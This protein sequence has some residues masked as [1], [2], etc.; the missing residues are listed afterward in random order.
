MTMLSWI[1]M[2]N[3]LNP[4][5]RMPK[6]HLI[7]LQWGRRLGVPSVLGLC[8]TTRLVS[9]SRG[10]ATPSIIPPHYPMVPIWTADMQ[11]SQMMGV[12]EGFMTGSL[13][14]S[15]RYRDHLWP[16]WHHHWN[17]DDWWRMVARIRPWW[18]LWNVPCQ[19]CW[20]TAVGTG[21]TQ[22]CNVTWHK[23]TVRKRAL[24]RI[25]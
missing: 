13:L 11:I 5:F 25:F 10:L 19:L 15:G 6:K 7:P 22:D 16:W 9:M 4:L 8:M 12:V 17:R 3:C 14:H 24:E 1:I 21:V 2:A 20:I 23:I 18:A